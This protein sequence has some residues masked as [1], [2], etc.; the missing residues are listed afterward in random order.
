MSELFHWR[1]NDIILISLLTLFPYSSFL[2][3]IGNPSDVCI[4]HIPYLISSLSAHSSFARKVTI[5]VCDQLCM[6]LFTP[7]L[8]SQVDIQCWDFSIH[9]LDILLIIILPT[10]VKV[11]LFLYFLFECSRDVLGVNMYP[12]LIQS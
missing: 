6:L 11:F 2:H 1:S 5:V 3:F 7:H 12:G 8:S 10:L 9:R 4:T